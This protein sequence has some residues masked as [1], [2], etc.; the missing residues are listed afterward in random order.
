MRPE[1]RPAS[2]KMSPDQ[3]VA[4]PIELNQ[5][6]ASCE[7]DSAHMQM[8]PIFCVMSFDVARL[9]LWMLELPLNNEIRPVQVIPSLLKCDAIVVASNGCLH[10]TGMDNQRL[11]NDRHETNANSLAR[12]LENVRAKPLKIGGPGRCNTIARNQELTARCGPYGG[13]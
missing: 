3:I 7:F 11:T 1:I 6:A 12:T 8:A 4:G 10:P 5:Q 9:I 2:E 13:L